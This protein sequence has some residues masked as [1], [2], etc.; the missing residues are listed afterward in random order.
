[1]TG[2][3]AN[4]VT[5]VPAGWDRLRDLG[6]DHGLAAGLAAVLDG[7]D[8]ALAAAHRL[9]VLPVAD[10]PDG[11]H[12]VP[13]DLAAREGLAVVRLRA[14]D[15]PMGAGL[16][17]HR[18]DALAAVRVGVLARMLDLAVERL[19][20]RRFDGVPLI[21]QQVVR[22]AVADVVTG[23]ELATATRVELAPAAVWAAQHEHLTEL[24]WT[25]T[26]FFGAEG[27]IADHPA[28]SL[29]VSALVAD[30]WIARTAATEDG[31][32]HVRP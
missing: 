16:T 2:I 19:A 13:N 8:P 26:R 12:P 17:G 24:G 10:L 28:R 21:E 27:Y 11:A 32:G 29:Y 4:E 20:G 6:R 15:A 7:L 1:M 22:G 3:A 25:V 14:T 23:I 30:V 9:A 5:T 31:N 18:V